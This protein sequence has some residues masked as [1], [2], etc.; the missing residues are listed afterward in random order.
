M[1]GAESSLGQQGPIKIS[2]RG[3]LTFYTDEKKI[4]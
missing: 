1:L 3:D 4:N 2:V